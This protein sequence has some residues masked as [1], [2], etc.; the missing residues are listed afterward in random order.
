MTHTSTNLTKVIVCLILTIFLTGCGNSVN[1]ESLKNEAET[2]ASIDSIAESYV[3]LVLEVGLYDKD[4]VDAYY[5]PEE[6]RPAKLKEDAVFPHQ[7]LL[8]RVSELSAQIALVDIS[9]NTPLQQARHN[10]LVKQLTA[11]GAK[12]N[13]IAGNN[14]SF[15]EEALLLYDAKPPS[16]EWSH[17]DQLLAELDAKVP[18]DGPLTQRYNTYRKAFEIPE[19]KLEKVFQTAIKEARVRT[20]KYIELPANENFVLEFVK[21]KPWGGYNYYQGNAQ[22]LIQVNTDFPIPIQRVIDLAAHEGYP[23][24][25]VYN[26]LLEQDLVNEKGWIEF[27][28]LPLF[29]P[30]AFIAEGTANYG[31][32]IAFP[33][34]KRINYEKDVLFPLAGLNP[35]DADLYYEILALVGK[36]N[37]ASNEIA[38]A[39]L[40]GVHTREETKALV[41]KYTMRSPEHAESFFSFVDS[42]RSY[43]INYNMGK[44]TVAAYMERQGAI[45]DN[46]ERRWQVFTDLL[47]SPN[48]A[49]SISR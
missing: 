16:F 44:D 5:G 6:W 22:S 42:Y 10:M 12:I 33:G 29:S 17:F 39:Y 7:R 11:I 9:G 49:S 26:L 34:D 47:N 30:Q 25:H 35:E 31:I 27:S 38:R 48:T 32:D 28:I 45:A 41:I 43:V 19:D 23:G 20:K 15:D 18:G 13:I 46:P 1:T 4:V 21:D 24:H 14:Y 2:T 8:T 37:Y 36:L 40:N 3:K